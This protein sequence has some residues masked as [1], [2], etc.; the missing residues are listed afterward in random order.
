RS[1]TMPAT[2]KAAGSHGAGQHDAGVSSVHR[3]GQEHPWR[4]LHTSPGR[5]APRGSRYTRLAGLVR[6]H[7]HLTPGSGKGRYQHTDTSLANPS[8]TVATE[9]ALPL[10]AHKVPRLTLLPPGLAPVVCPGT[11]SAPPAGMPN[12]VAE[13]TAVPPPM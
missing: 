5:P 1:G 11:T 3:S 2:R 6:R 13:V 9:N 7:A 8:E 12:P 4:G 10:T